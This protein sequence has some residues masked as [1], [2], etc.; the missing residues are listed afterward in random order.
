MSTELQPGVAWPIILSTKGIGIISIEMT[1]IN[2]QNMPT[3]TKTSSAKYLQLPPLTHKRHLTY[4]NSRN[5][6]KRVEARLNIARNSALTFSG[7]EF[8]SF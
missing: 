5:P 3:R 7:E 6:V 4:L 2:A 1:A 8:T